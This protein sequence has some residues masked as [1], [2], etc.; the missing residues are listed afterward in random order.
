MKYSARRIV[1]LVPSIVALALMPTVTPA[2]AAWHSARTEGGMAAFTN[3]GKPAVPA[4]IAVCRNGAVILYMNL[5][6]DPE[7]GGRTIGFRGLTSSRYSE[8]KFVRDISTGSWV[9]QPSAATLTL[10]NDDEFTLSVTLSGMSIAGIATGAYND[11]GPDSGKGVNAALRPVFAA[12]PNWRQQM[13]ANAVPAVNAAASRKKPKMKKTASP[14]PLRPSNPAPISAP[15]VP[16]ANIPARIPLVPGYYAYV[17]GQFS[18]CAKPVISPWYFDGTRFWEETDQT[19]PQHLYSPQALKWEMV[20]ADR[21][22]IS[23][24]SRGQARR[25][26]LRQSVNEYV[27][28]GP[29]SFTF[30]GAVGGPRYNEKYQSC[31]ASL[32]PAKARWYRGAK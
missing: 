29:Q 21:F 17:E 25:W 6:M 28:T 13:S 18:T 19:D 20:A 26:D 23:Y 11:Q 22:Q 27:L 1:P 8:E 7:Q 24:R 12:C 30:V 14:A 31:P 10:F 5:A 3:D 4:V 9:T 16:T 2:Q 15:S 32:L